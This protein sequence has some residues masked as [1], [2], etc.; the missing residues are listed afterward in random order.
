[1]YSIL[2]CRLESHYN[3]ANKFFEAPDGQSCRQVGRRIHSFFKRTHT[4]ASISQMDNTHI[5]M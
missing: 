5:N 3:N 2:N 4:H 1:M